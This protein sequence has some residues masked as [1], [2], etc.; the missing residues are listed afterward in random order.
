MKKTLLLAGALSLMA[1]AAFAS[2]MWESFGVTAKPMDAEKIAAA[3][4]KFM[5]SPEGKKFP[6]KMFLM[7]NQG[8]GA[9]PT[10]H[11]W[12]LLYNSAADAETWGNSLQGSKAWTDFMNAVVPIS[13]PTADVRYKLLKSWGTADDATTVWQGHMI[14]ASNPAAVVAA[15]DKWF[16]SAKGKQFPGEAYLSAPV[17]A[18]LSPVTHFISVGY[19][20]EAEMEAW[21]DGEEGDP[22]YA[23]FIKEVSSAADYLGGT[24]SREVKEWGKPMGEMTN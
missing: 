6:G 18:G 1:T 17:A 5:N 22:D 7:A 24:L 13:T 10:T 12:V 16:A 21:T 15:M 4:D 2:P 14:K 9:D 3:T 23:A 19:K 20:S 8:N 11:S